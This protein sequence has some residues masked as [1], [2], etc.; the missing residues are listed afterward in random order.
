MV[1]LAD[2]DLDLEFVSLGNVEEVGV[3]VQDSEACTRKAMVRR[4]RGFNFAVSGPCHRR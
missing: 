1:N 2:V 4:A 3:V